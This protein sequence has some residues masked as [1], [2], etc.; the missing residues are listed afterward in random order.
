M[1]MA[2]KRA[3]PHATMEAQEPESA[4]SGVGR[5]QFEQDMEKQLTNRRNKLKSTMGVLVKQ[6]AAEVK[7]FLSQ[8]EGERVLQINLGG[9]GR[10]PDA[11]SS[12]RQI[13]IAATAVAV[14]AAAH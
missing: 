5:E 7:D 12:S 11:T 13:M 14:A 9:R 6:H 1:Y 10:S 4:G 2:N 3:W 8:P